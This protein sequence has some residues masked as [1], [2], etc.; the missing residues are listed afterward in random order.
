MVSSRFF[1][2]EALVK[3]L[4]CRTVL[5]GTC[6]MVCSAALLAVWM[7][8][9]HLGSHLGRHLSGYLVAPEVK[10]IASLP[11]ICLTR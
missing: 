9:P 1:R 7:W 3:L 6:Y 5:R 11:L 8:Y 4:V 2:M 10:G